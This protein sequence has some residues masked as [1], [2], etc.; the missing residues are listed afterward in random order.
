MSEN[1]DQRLEIDIDSIANQLEQ[2]VPF[3]EPTN[4]FDVRLEAV[5]LIVPY[6]AQQPV[7]YYHARLLKLN[8]I[9]PLKQM[10]TES[11]A[12]L[13]KQALQGLVNLSTSENGR[14]ELIKKN[15]VEAVMDHVSQLREFRE[16]NSESVPLLFML[17]SNLTME[18]EGQK[19][20]LQIGTSLQGLW[21]LRLLKLFTNDL[22][23]ESSFGKESDEYEYIANILTNVTQQEVG[24]VLLLD[25]RRKIMPLLIEQLKSKSRVRK[26]GVLRLIRNLSFEL[27]K[28]PILFG[29][30][31]QLIVELLVPL[32]AADLIDQEEWDEMPQILK[33][34]WTSNLTRETDEEILKL[35][36][37]I[38]DVLVRNI[39]TRNTLKSMK[40][41]SFVTF[42]FIIDCITQ[43]FF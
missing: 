10:I 20:F 4:R 35:I 40:T 25:E 34:Q 14:I 37:E 12:R 39:D 36:L 17:L 11:N 43:F 19:R 21:L 32:M 24:R 33:D 23:T 22:R 9:R 29:E 18:D 6:L 41:V 5:G 15:L 13:S 28:H 8:L 2:V 31:N 42:E 26:L 16:L 38:L 30:K 1:I 27:E 7:E 3:L